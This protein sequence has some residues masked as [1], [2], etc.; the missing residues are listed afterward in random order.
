MLNKCESGLFYGIL[1]YE[2][3]L[4]SLKRIQQVANYFMEKFETLALDN[5]NESH[6][7]EI[8]VGLDK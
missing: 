1:Y 4:K 6:T 2:G 8:Y 3:I 7:R 5:G